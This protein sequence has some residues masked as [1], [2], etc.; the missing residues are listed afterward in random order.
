M[1]DIEA[2]FGYVQTIS[3][4]LFRSVNRRRVSDDDRRSLI[5]YTE[6]LLTKLKEIPE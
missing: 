4:M 1:E 5:Y 6:L 2:L 3:N